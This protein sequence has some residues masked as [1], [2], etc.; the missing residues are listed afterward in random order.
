MK[1]RS[2]E[3]RKSLLARR[4]RLQTDTDVVQAIPEVRESSRQQPTWRA[5]QNDGLFAPALRS[6]TRPRLEE[7]GWP[8]AWRPR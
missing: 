1:S 4:R 5:R 3:S 7:V 8:P 2:K 6:L